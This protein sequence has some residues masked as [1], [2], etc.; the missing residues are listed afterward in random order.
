MAILDTVKKFGLRIK[1]ATGYITYKLGSE[2]VQMDNGKDLQTAFDDLNDE[3]N[4]KIEENN[5]VNFVPSTYTDSNGTILKIH[6]GVKVL[7]ASSSS[8]SKVLF[9]RQQLYDIFETSSG[10]PNRFCCVAT[11]GDGSANSAHIE[12]TTCINGELRIV[13]NTG[14]ANAIR[15]IF[16]VFYWE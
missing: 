7:P 16:T 6:S 12:G 4:S 10:F 5:T 11:N 15:V 13:L 9:T 3:L 2:F 8:S 1:T 14:T